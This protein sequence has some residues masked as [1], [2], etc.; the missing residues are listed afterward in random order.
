M[1]IDQRGVVD[2]IGIS[3]SDGSLYLTIS[4]HLD[5]EDYDSHAD[6]I[7]GKI[8]DLLT[9]TQRPTLTTSSTLHTL[10]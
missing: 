7:Q 10:F 4:D 5:W 8:N 1:T 3:R 2:F 6:S 9:V